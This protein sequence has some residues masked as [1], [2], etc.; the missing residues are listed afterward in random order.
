MVGSK[1]ADW[2]A[3]VWEGGW[4]VVWAMATVAA[5]VEAREAAVMWEE[6]DAVAQV[7]EHAVEEVVVV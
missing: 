2:A 4:A 7:V 6:A 1:V 5:N 3:A